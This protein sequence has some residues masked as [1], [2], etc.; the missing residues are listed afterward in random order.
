MTLTLDS[1]CPTLGTFAD[2][3]HGLPSEYAHRT[4]A[5][6]PH[7]SITYGQLIAEARAFAAYLTHLGIRKGDSVALWLGNRV[8]WLIAQF[9][10]YESG[11]VLVPLNP[12][13]KA[14]EVA[15]ILRDS[16][17]RLIVCEPTFLGRIDVRAILNEA[18]E[19]V[20]PGVLPLG[21]IML[22]AAGTD[23]WPF[24]FGDG[25]RE[26]AVGRPHT[27]PDD[28]CQIMYT[29]GTTGTP[30]GVKLSS[31]GLLTT[32]AAV[33]GGLSLDGSASWLL[34]L[35]LSTMFG[36]SAIVIPTVLT[37]SRLVL[38]ERFDV[39][40]VLRAVECAGEGPI[41]HLAGS[42][43]VYQMLLDAGLGSRSHHLRGGI[44]AGSVAA[45]EVL[46]T[47]I[48]DVPIPSLV[49][50]FGQTEGCG[51]ACMTVPA[52]PILKRL[53]TVGRPLP[54]VE[55]RIRSVDGANWVQVGEVGE[56][57]GRGL[58]PG[59]HNLVG[60]TQPETTSAVDADGWLH[61]GD[62][63]SIDSDGYVSVGRGRLKDMYVS[64]GYNVYPPE[65]ESILLTHPRITQA[66]V[67]GVPDDRMG[68]VGVAWIV[69]AASD[70]DVTESDIHTWCARHLSHYKAPSHI[71]IV[72]TLP[73]TPSGKVRHTGLR[74][75][76]ELQRGA[77][78]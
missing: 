75:E 1:E 68:E 4:V 28:V 29:S 39:D 37:G 22:D 71:N 77:A 70:D 63:G 34:S 19:L 42:P 69:L 3:L 5:V 65:V 60:Y 64:G 66:A 40:E 30:K 45:P 21:R 26:N 62:L 36:C 46:R 51:T 44:I 76:W 23:E 48:E 43:T 53:S 31:R 54:H 41:T 12:Q 55:M 18:C 27:D 13:F 6:D 67:I 9:G 35:P 38:H 52:D 72:T 32:Y 73:T 25:P 56:I 8:E 15:H 33:A 7:R 59:L 50:M 2:L 16:A 57:C 78:T 58:R 17:A 14:A 49:N 20:G 74:A 11:G 61:Y 47:L 24:R 10:V